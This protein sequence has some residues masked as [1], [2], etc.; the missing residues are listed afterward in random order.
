MYILFFWCKMSYQIMN[1]N[2]CFGLLSKLINF[3][4]LIFF[5]EEVVLSIS[6]IKCTYRLMHEVVGQNGGVFTFATE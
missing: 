1:D 5:S 2:V 6:N 3:Y 4:S